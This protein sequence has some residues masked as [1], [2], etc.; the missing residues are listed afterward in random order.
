MKKRMYFLWNSFCMITTCTLAATMLYTNVL[1]PTDAVTPDIL[2]Q[3]LVVAFLCTAS[4]LLY[5]WEHTPKKAEFCIRVGIHYIIINFIILFFGN[6]F[7]WYRIT[8]FKSVLFMLV[9]IAVIF[10]LV[11]IA[12]SS[13]SLKDTK[14]M[15][16]RLKKYQNRTGHID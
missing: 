1:F 11:S 5:P 7:E 9:T 2:W 13:R 12:S 16:E 8:S 4:T 6:W 3:I 10:I 14:E 15:N